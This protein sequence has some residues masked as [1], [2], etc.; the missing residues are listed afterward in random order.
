MHAPKPS[1]EQL[2]DVGAALADDVE[3]GDAAVDDAVLH[4]L[5]DVVRAHEQPFDRRVA[6]RE[7]ERTVAGRLRPEPRV[8]EQRDRRLAQPAL[9]GDRD[10]Q[11]RAARRSS[12]SR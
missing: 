4:V 7:R 12:A 8:L 3:A 11:D 1:A 2:V 6:A 5:G 10:P 9:G